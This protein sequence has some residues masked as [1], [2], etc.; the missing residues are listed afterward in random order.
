MTSPNPADA[1]RRWL[2]FA[3]DDLVVAE[4]V[5]ATGDLAPHIGCYH[6]QQCG[7]KALK[8]V[9]VFLQIRYPFSRDLDDIRDL[10]PQSWDVVTAHPDLS[11]LR[12]WATV[13]R[14]P[15]N[16]P[17]TTDKDARDSARQARAVWDTVL[18]DPARHGLDVSRFC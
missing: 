6:A 2:Q 9:L 5:A 4:R 13:G 11:S 17:E 14:Y 15:G 18:D 7:E 1:A 8:A 10:I 12:K 3:R 16:W